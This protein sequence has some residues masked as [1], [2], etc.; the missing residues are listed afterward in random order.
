MGW[1][2]PVVML[3]GAYQ[4]YS[5][6]KSERKAA[7]AQEALAAE[8]QALSERNAQREEAETT[9]RLRRQEI[10][11]SKDEAL[12]RAGAFASG[13][14]ATGMAPGDVN[15][16]ALSLA[17]QKQENLTQIDWETRAGASRADIIR[18]GGAIARQKGEAE[19]D[20]MKRKGTASYW[21]ALGM[22]LGGT[23]SASDWWTKP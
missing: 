7:S 2:A 12:A 23:K 4:Q 10:Q 11:F 16:I 5:A 18:K 21:G 9:E 6:G 3:M 22:G 1:V 19:A 8:Q 20:Y 13:F 15:S 17:E 14:Q